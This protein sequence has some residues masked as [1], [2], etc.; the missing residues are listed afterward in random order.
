MKFS[1]I[2]VSLWIKFR[3][4]VFSPEKLKSRPPTFGLVNLYLLGSPALESLSICGPAGYFN[5]ITLP[6][7][8][9]ASPAASSKF[10]LKLAYRKDYLL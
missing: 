1:S 2:L 4:F 10:P 5:P 7:L 6:D 9:K 8:S 3:K